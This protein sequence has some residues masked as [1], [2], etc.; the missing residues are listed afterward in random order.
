MNTITQAAAEEFKSAI[1]ADLAKITAEVAW[2]ISVAVQAAELGLDADA[3]D[4][5]AIGASNRIVEAL[6]SAVKMTYHAARDARPA[7]RAALAVAIEAIRRRALSVKQ[8]P[9]HD[10][11][12]VTG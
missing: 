10:D 3:A 7:S 12:N 1:D 6:R 5:A 11:P 8:Q 9:P 4:S 2:A